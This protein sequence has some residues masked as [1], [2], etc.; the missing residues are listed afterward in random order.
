MLEDFGLVGVSRMDRV[1]NEVV[2]MRAG[3]E[4]ELASTADQ[5]AS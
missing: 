1:R 3:I 5:R 4:G 2:H